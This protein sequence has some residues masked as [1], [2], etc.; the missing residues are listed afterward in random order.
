MTDFGAVPTNIPTLTIMDRDF[1]EI[2]G[3]TTVSATL[4][5]ITG[6]TFNLTVPTG[7]TGTIEAMMT[8][9]CSA[10]AANITG[11]WAISI[12]AADQQEVQR[13]MST[14]NE[15]GSMMVQGQTTGLTAGDYTVKGRHRRVSGANTVNTEVAQLIAR[16]VLE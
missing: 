14:G 2:T 9:Q 3:E 6:L 4:E 13:T 8:V 11:A 1:D 5:D 12:N 7:V 15:S 10:G 16:V